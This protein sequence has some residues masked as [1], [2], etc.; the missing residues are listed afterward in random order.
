MLSP[1]GSRT[2]SGMRRT[3]INICSYWMVQSI[4]LKCGFPSQ[5]TAGWDSSNLDLVPGIYQPVSLAPRGSQWTQ[6]K[7]TLSETLLYELVLCAAL[8][9]KML[10][11][12]DSSSFTRFIDRCV[13]ILL[14]GCLE[15]KAVCCERRWNHASF[16]K[17]YI[18]I[19]SW[20]KID[21]HKCKF[22]VENLGHACKMRRYF[23]HKTD[24]WVL[25]K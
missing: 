12:N 18:Y 17:I 8:P 23:R 15:N 4:Y 7:T 3:P 1:W 25:R 24:M 20:I 14:L 13:L 6:P 11:K 21:E 16:Q 9:G 19:F 2:A 10:L 22:K 5:I